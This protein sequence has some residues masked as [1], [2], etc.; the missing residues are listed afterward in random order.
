MRYRALVILTFTLVALAAA[1]SRRHPPPGSQYVMA[2]VLLRHELAAPASHLG[3]HGSRCPCYVRV[4]DQDMPAEHAA[5]LANTGVTFLPES[6][7]SSG[8]GLRVH[9]GLPRTR[10]NGN[11]DVAVG[12]GC[13]AQRC[14]QSATTLLRYDG[15]RWRVID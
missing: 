7:W 11:F 12:Y 13:D 4:G 2:E 8:K 5:A 1:C 9:I 6:A 14:E 10:W 15:S 3:A